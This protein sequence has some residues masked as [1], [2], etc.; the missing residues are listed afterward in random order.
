MKV[1]RWLELYLFLDGHRVFYRLS[2]NIP[3]YLLSVE[4]VMRLPIR[5]LITMRKLGL[6]QAQWFLCRMA[7]VAKEHPSYLRRKILCQ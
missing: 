6:K 4:Y 7:Q 5:E 1:T 3:Y 2:E